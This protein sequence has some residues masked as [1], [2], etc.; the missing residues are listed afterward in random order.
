MLLLIAILILA[1]VDRPAAK[2]GVDDRV[3]GLYYVTQPRVVVYSTAD[4]SKPYLELR[5]REQVRIVGEEG[6]WIQVRTTDGAHGYVRRGALSNIWIRVS[7]KAQ[8]LWV[9]RG[10][11][12]L[13]KLPV[14][15]GYNYFANKEKRGSLED[16]D[17]WRTPE[18]QFFVVSKN[19]RSQFYKAFV[20]N[21]PTAEDAERGLQS[22]MIS[23]KERDAIVRAEAESSMPPMNTALGGWIEIHGQGTGARSNW[24]QGC[25]AL[26]NAE[27]DALWSLVDVGAPVLIEP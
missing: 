4:A 27:M 17:H 6:E 15:L 7:K 11:D 13:T 23:R 14:D 5:L 8:T 3:E 19:P 20:L 9:Y 18:G 24:T 1:P 26:R 2:G 22:G 25:V 12:L 21:Y 10:A 16:R